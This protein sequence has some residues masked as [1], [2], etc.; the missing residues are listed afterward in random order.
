MEESIVIVGAGTAGV[1]A[2]SWLR[3]HSFEGRVTLL[4]AETVA[5]YQRPPLSK[6]F[7][8]TGARRP[9]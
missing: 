8:A 4:S 7:L 2:A 6:A 3:Q 1:Y 5:P 9:G